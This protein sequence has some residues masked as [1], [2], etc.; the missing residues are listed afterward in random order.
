MTKTETKNEEMSQQLLLNK[1]DQE[2]HNGD[3]AKGEDAQIEDRVPGLTANWGT[4]PVS[5]PASNRV[6]LP[7]CQQKGIQ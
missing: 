7:R 6:C 1:E 2:L 3:L 5:Y 4:W